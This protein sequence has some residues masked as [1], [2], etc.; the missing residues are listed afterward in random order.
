MYAKYPDKDVRLDVSTTAAPSIQT[1]P[2][3]T[4]MACSLSILWSVFVNPTTVEKAFITSVDLQG[5]F[6]NA[7]IASVAGGTDINVYGALKVTSDVKLTQSFMGDVNVT[8]FGKIVQ[9][10]IINGQVARFNQQLKA[11]IPLGLATALPG[12]TVDSAKLVV[13]NGYVA[14]DGNLNYTPTKKVEQSNEAKLLE[15]LFMMAKKIENLQDKVASLEDK[16]A[17]Q[18]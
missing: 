10:L 6:T 7:S 14:V 18:K 4:N 9:L 11:G 17:C 16:V 1:T 5:Q 2:T 15:L 13:N 3:A 8:T 12:V